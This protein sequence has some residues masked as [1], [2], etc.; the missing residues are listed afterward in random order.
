MKATL[1]PTWGTSTTTVRPGKAGKHLPEDYASYLAACNAK[2][3]A[4][5]DNSFTALPEHLWRSSAK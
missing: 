4:T 1:N 2:V 3:K 5:R